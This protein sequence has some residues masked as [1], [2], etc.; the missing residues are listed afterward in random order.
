GS[1]L[2]STSHSSV[3]RPRTL[4]QQPQRASPRR[5]PCSPGH[6]LAQTER[7]D[8]ETG[9]CSNLLRGI[10]I[11]RHS[12]PCDLPVQV[13][14]PRISTTECSMT[15]SENPLA[16]TNPEDIPKLQDEPESRP[17]GVPLYVWVVGA[18]LVAIPV[19]L[20]WGEGATSLELMPKLILR[21]LTALAAPLV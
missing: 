13:A 18:V 4:R 19:G 1:R 12:N 6:R 8:T 20:I 10:A 11:I 9:P 17:G 7:S 14:V 5:G 2:E 21:A 15:A 16:D 3:G